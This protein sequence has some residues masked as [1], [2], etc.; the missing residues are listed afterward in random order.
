MNNQSGLISSSRTPSYGQYRSLPF[1]SKPQIGHF[2]IFCFCPRNG[3]NGMKRNRK[4]K[5]N[6]RVQRRT[7]RPSDP[8]KRTNERI[9]RFVRKPPGLPMLASHQ[10]MIP[11]H[12]SDQ[13]HQTRLKG[14][15]NQFRQ[16][17][18]GYN[19]TYP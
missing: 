13:W 3:I 19:D 12:D 10:N 1:V 11:S 2:R 17:L 6:P 14:A 4:K 15:G 7:L 16:L 5:G 18:S 8:K 9:R